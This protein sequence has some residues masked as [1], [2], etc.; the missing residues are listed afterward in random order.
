MGR[1][2]AGGLGLSTHPSQEPLLD[3]DVEE[4]VEREMMLAHIMV[5]MGLILGNGDDGTDTGMKTGSKMVNEYVHKYKDGFWPFH[6]SHLLKQRVA[7]SETAMSDVLFVSFLTFSVAV[8]LNMWR[9]NGSSKVLVHQVVVL[10]KSLHADTC[11][12]IV[13]GLMY[14]HSHFLQ[15]GTV[16]IADFSVSQAFEND[17]DELSRRSPGTPVS[18]HQSAAW[19]PSLSLSF[20]TKLPFLLARREQREE[21]AVGVLALQGSFNEHIAALRR[22]GVKG[23]EIRKAEQLQSVSSLI[24]PGGESTTMAKLAEFHNLI[25][26]LKRLITGSKL[27]LQLSYAYVFVIAGNDSPFWFFN[28]KLSDGKY[29]AIKD[30]GKGRVS[31]MVSEQEWVYGDP[32]TRASRQ[33]F[34]E[35][36]ESEQKVIVAVKQGN[37]LATAFHPE[38]TAD[39]RWHSYFLKMVPEFGGTSS[40]ITT[41]GEGG[42]SFYERPRIDLPVFQ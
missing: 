34:E 6:K 28:R 21:M 36:A 14:L 8:F 13:S 32:R 18:L 24:I 23:I 27:K 29:H 40:M 25:G 12:D 19:A 37:M 16:K 11:G 15:L 31:G 5:M 4:D 3:E 2:P 42:S 20:T 22:L 35:S 30:P 39:T 1:D 17:D 7:Q 41:T 9:A 38:L 10:E 26:A 33:R